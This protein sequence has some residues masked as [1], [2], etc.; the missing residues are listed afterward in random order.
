MQTT[1]SLW[2]LKPL[3]L[4]KTTTK[5]LALACLIST[6]AA[7]AQEL[8]V[9]QI[10]SQIKA[11]KKDVRGPYYRIKW[12][13]DDGTIREAKD[14]CPD[15]IGGIQ[16]ASLKSDVEK[17]GKKHHI[18]FGNLLVQNENEDFWDH[19][20]NHS[21][22]KQYQIVKYLQSVDEGWIY[23]RGQF[24]RG[25]MQ[26]EDEQA[27]GLEFYKWLLKNKSYTKG[28]FF[29][30]K[31]SLHDIPHS[32]DSNL[33]Q[34]MRSES[35]VLGNEI[36]SFMKLRIKIHGNPEKR[37]IASVKSFVSKHN[38]DLSADQ[39]K[40]FKTLLATMED[41]YKPL[42]I[43][44]IK[45][46]SN[47][48]SNPHKTELNNLL[49]PYN[50]GLSAK[51]KIETL[52][53]VL[54]YIREH[55]EG[56]NSA[57]DKLAALDI[58]NKIEKTVF[59]NSQEWTPNDLNGIL[60]KI[61]YLSYVAAST[62]LIELWE[63]NKIK[64]TL[65]KY[66]NK[67][68]LTIA[69]LNKVL[70]TSRSVVEWS[71]GMVKANYSE[72]VETYSQFEP[73]SYGFIDDKIRSSIALDLGNSVG[74]LG[75]YISEKS[76]IK[77]EVI[78]VSKPATIRG[79]NPGYAFGE[80]VVVEGSI[81]NINFSKDKIYVFNRPPSGLKPIAGIMTVSEGNLVS[82]VQLL[83]RNLG[84]P[85]A[86]L[87][88]ENL[89]DLAKYNGKK[90]FYAVSTK[91]NVIVKT[92]GQMSSEE[93]ALF[94][95]V[96]RSTNKITVPVDRIQ[97]DQTDILNMREVDASDSGKL[98][99]P[100]AANLSQLKSMFPDHVVEG[101]VIPFGI[102]RKH[103]DNQMTGQNMTYWAFL[104]QTYAECEAM[105]KA[106]KTENEVEA[107]QFKRLSTLRTAIINMDLNPD[108]IAQ[109]RKNFIDA[110]KK[111]IG[112]VPVFLRSDTNMEDLKEFTGAG[113]NLTLFNVLAEQKIIEGIKKVWASPYMERSLKWRQ[114]YL[115]NPEYVFPSILVI[116]GVNVDYSGVVVTTGINAGGEDD[117]TI[118]F[119][120]GVGG[121][122]DG[123]SAETRMVSKH[124]NL[125]LS[126]SREPSF[127]TLPKTGGTNRE[128][129][130]F[131]DPI[132]SEK[133]M[134]SIREMVE[135]VRKKM[136]E[137]TG[138]D[139]KGPYD[140]EMGFQNDKL[141]LFQIR[142]FVQNKKASSSKYLKSI[143]PKV[144][145]N[146]NIPLNSNL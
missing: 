95:K 99:G 57:N 96:E 19:K 146:Q 28:Q 88:Q 91:G 140:M 84:V 35:K 26:S 76:S 144:N 142:P 134:Q 13:C 70:S 52:G 66:K 60:Q 143:T 78:G 40:E 114:K 21:R 119:S 118:A 32:G 56:L 9:D 54:M 139:Y 10:K 69:E 92:E 5:I 112:E 16:H 83:A 102:F 74:V 98:C 130:T 71:A 120:R 4:R 126:P 36:S 23:R 44:D 105:K 89:D 125:L 59:Q 2:G 79:L 33:A 67:K 49:A 136:P 108:F 39:K 20:H 45:G 46:L 64:S 81:E 29:L 128:Y 131:E 82:H 61:D 41:Y 72:I 85:N 132:L 58:S 75:K 109:L 97:L 124:N 55:F 145:Y 7:T 122:V 87:S 47:Q 3:S 63:Y 1:I 121:A 135:Q 37:D 103:L 94:S 8:P 34:K 141:W 137:Q 6:S 65:G 48:L 53:P 11:Y 80:L 42:N 123:Q 129:T 14:P 100:K 73:L 12:F 27:W 106:N 24:Y 43:K 15:E 111:P 133:N 138:S 51:D 110:F 62:G 101:F 113:L 116:P 30:L 115:L 38:S 86:A 18:F 107:Y 117:L 17:L 90:V 93:K 22:L 50:A 25:A 127:L 104:T 31:Q 77:N 68:Q